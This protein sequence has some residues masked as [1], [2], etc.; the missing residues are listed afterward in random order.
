MPSILVARGDSDQGTP[1]RRLNACPG[2]TENGNARRSW[3]VPLGGVNHD[4]TVRL[5]SDDLVAEDT[6][7]LGIELRTRAPA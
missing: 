4:E 3:P 7:D 5:G 2:F 6:D 1:F